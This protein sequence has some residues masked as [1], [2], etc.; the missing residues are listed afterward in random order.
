MVLDLTSLPW[1]VKIRNKNLA[2]K[3]ERRGKR[4]GVLR[5]EYNHFG[6]GRRREKTLLV[7]KWL[8]QRVWRA[9]RH[10]LS[11]QKWQDGEVSTA[12]QSWHLSKLLKACLKARVPELE[13]SDG[14][15]TRS[16][17]IC[18]TSESQ[19]VYFKVNLSNFPFFLSV[20]WKVPAVLG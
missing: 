6:L 7:S 5:V 18:R 1:T 3:S 16:K 10:V 11:D 15:C 4:S 12:S 19:C 20:F 13:S 2:E 14:F 8:E 17:S 9:R